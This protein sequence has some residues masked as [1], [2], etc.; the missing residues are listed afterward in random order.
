MSGSVTNP[1][2]SVKG[3]SLTGLVDAY[4]GNYSGSELALPPQWQH[5]VLL[6]DQAGAC[7]R[8]GSGGSYASSELTVRLTMIGMRD[9]PPGVLPPVQPPAGDLPLTFAVPTP[10]PWPATSDG[11]RRY[12]QP[13]FMQ[14]GRNGNGGT[15]VTATAGTVTFAQM[16]SGVYVGSY[17]LYWGADHITGQFS[18]PWC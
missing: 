7:V 18:A 13:Y 5:V 15:P 11:V 16:D 14:A 8:E 6:S 12:L 4:T 3:K 10:E 2:G 9:D 17:D 1:T